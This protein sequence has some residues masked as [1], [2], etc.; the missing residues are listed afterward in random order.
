[1]KTSTKLQLVAGFF[2]LLGYILLT[3][4]ILN[5]PTPSN[6]GLYITIFCSSVVAVLL[7]LGSLLYP[8]TKK[9]EVKEALKFPTSEE[10]KKEYEQKFQEMIASGDGSETSPYKVQG[11]FGTFSELLYIHHV[12]NINTPTIYYLDFNHNILTIYIP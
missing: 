4:I 6:P 5:L 10:I 3:I 7:A 9:E 8:R 2:V 1:M 11:N 12:K